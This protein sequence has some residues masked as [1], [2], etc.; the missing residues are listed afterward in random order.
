MNIYNQPKTIE[1][2]AM[3][4][5]QYSDSSIRQLAEHL[6]TATGLDTKDCTIGR[7]VCKTLCTDNLEATELWLRA[8]LANSEES[9]EHIDLDKYES[10]FR[11]VL[12]Q[13]VPAHLLGGSE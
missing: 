13:R 3:T 6:C 1:E 9:S 10:A 4:A 2:L 5:N 7:F 12:H 11:V 8:H